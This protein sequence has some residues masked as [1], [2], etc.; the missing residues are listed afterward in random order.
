M[1]TEDKGKWKILQGVRTLQVHPIQHKH[2]EKDINAYMR[3][4]SQ[5][6][7]KLTNKIS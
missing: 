5:L 1:I 6:E 2:V 7:N 3:A 4:Q